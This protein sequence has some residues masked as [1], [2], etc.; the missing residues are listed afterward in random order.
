[1]GWIRWAAATVLLTAAS[2]VFASTL[3]G[4]VKDDVGRLLDGVEVLVLAPEAPATGTLLRAVSDASGRFVIGS[5]APGVYRVAAIKPGYVAALGR[6][7]TVL[8]SSVDLVLRPVPKEGEPGAEKVLDDLSWTLRIPPR[9]IFR[10]T[11]PA[12]AVPK[13]GSSGARAFA[14]RVQESMSGQV[15]HMVA[16]GSWR[17]SAS[18]ASSNVEGNETRMRLAGTLG[19][20]GAIELRGRRGSLGSA[21]ESVSRGAQAVDVDVSYDTNPDENLAMRAFYS[22]GDLAVAETSGG[23]GTGERQWQRSWGYDAQ[24]RK[25]VN[26]SSRV[27]LQVGF[28]DANLDAGHAT[29]IGWEPSTGDTSNR[30]IG[31][32]GSYEN[33]VADRHLL[34]VGVRAQRLTLSAP[35]VRVAGEPAQFALDGTAGWNLLVDSEDR[36]SLTGPL[37]MTYGLSVSEGF[38]GAGETTVSPRLGAAWAPGRLEASGELSYVPTSIAGRSP[39]GYEAE[40]KTRLAP[41]LTLRGSASYVPSRASVWGDQDAVLMRATPYVADASASD[42]VV[43]LDLEHVAP[44][45][46]LS[47]GVARGRAEGAIAPALDDAPVLLLADSALDYDV[48]RF[49]VKAPRAGSSVALLYRAIHEHAVDAS[50]SEPEELRVV[51][52]EF[53]Q[54]LVRFAGGRASCRLL[55]TARSALGPGTE[56]TGSGSADTRRLIAEQKRVGAGVSLAF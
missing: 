34:R 40:L 52:L 36:W 22:T 4:V 44:A 53:S 37:S 46:T 33:A 20:R 1:M 51:A 2:P 50:V 16:L 41:A 47:F 35:D 39:Y 42:R 12:E 56:A 54:D 11:D 13:G 18:G 48:L 19:E 23:A 6:V 32:E 7:N 30:A 26:A 28:H 5:I 38:D 43:S 29:A 24:W 25:Q 31:A 49:G 45:A 3:S 15:D 10:E 14:S 8:R 9:G 21:T 17:P 27:A 55:L